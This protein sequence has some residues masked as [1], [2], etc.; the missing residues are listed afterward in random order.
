MRLG[1]VSR[2]LVYRAA[3]HLGVL[4]LCAI[5]AFACTSTYRQ[6]VDAVYIFR[7]SLTGPGHCK[8]LVPAWEELAAGVKGRVNVAKV[9][10]TIP[11][12]ASD[13]I[14]LIDRFLC[15][16]IFG[17]AAVP[18]SHCNALRA[19]ACVCVRERC[20]VCSPFY[21]KYTSHRRQLYLR[22]S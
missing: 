13:S 19:C 15:I 8:K 2:P 17:R 20:N 9:D 7:S 10:C 4:G 1:V 14:K 16:L 21:K 5:A 11:G 22:E 12:P 3:R 18:G 6:F